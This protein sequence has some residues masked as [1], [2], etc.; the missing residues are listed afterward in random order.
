MRIR[1]FIAA[2]TALAS[3]PAAAADDALLGPMASELRARVGRWCVEARLQLTPQARQ[4]TIHALA[5]SR[6]VGDRWLLTQMR[7]PGFDG[8]G[9]NGFDPATGRYHGYWADGTRGFAVPVDGDYDRAGR[10]FRTLSTERRANGESVVVR[11]ET[12]P[13]GPDEEATIF[14]VPDSAGRPYERMR[15][16]SR[17]ARDGVDCPGNPA[18]A[19]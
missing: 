16:T 11:S 18:M 13:N 12:R 14:T 2:F 7:G 1:T 10:V 8:V 5:E 15:L 6:L 19:R 4:V 9:L 17:R 3:T